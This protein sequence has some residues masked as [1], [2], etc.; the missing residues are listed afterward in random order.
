MRSISYKRRLNGQVFDLLKAP[1]DRK[2]YFGGRRGS[3]K[4][5]TSKVYRAWTALVRRRLRRLRSTI[6]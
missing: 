6:T 2:M 1:K 4:L 3:G 5:S